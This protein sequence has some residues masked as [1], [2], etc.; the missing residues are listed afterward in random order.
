ME[1]ANK[2]KAHLGVR[3]DDV[4]V[5][6]QTISNEACSHNHDTGQNVADSPDKR[7]SSMQLIREKG[8][9]KI[10]IQ[11]HIDFGNNCDYPCAS[12]CSST[13]LI[14]V[15]NIMCFET[16]RAG[17]PQMPHAGKSTR[18]TKRRSILR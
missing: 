10:E 2:A 11:A 4:G 15:K 5:S 14:V 18:G 1:Q 16:F 7:R 13:S 6:E 3:V 17:P 9:P 12:H 8:H